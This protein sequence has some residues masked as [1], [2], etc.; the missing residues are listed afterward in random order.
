MIADDVELIET[1]EYVQPE[2]HPRVVL[3]DYD[4]IGKQARV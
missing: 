1:M 3:V 4:K 2:F